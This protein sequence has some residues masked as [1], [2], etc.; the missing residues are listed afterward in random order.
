[1]RHPINYG[2]VI[3]LVALSLVEPK[4]IKHPEYL[5]YAGNVLQIIVQDNNQYRM[6]TRKKKTS[7]HHDETND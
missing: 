3:A 1:M 4:I 2:V 5:V 7:R 6:S